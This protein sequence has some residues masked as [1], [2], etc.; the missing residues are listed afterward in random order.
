MVP[1]VYAGSPIT[2]ARVGDGYS[3]AVSESAGSAQAESL[4]MPTPSVPEQLLDFDLSDMA[5]KVVT[6]AQLRVIQG[7]LEK[8]DCGTEAMCEWF[9][10]EEELNRLRHPV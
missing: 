7:Q 8:A 1:C 9:S 5:L 3:T 4:L 10:P 6:P 2:N